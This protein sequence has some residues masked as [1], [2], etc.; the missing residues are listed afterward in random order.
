MMIPFSRNGSRHAFTLIELLVVITIIG[1][2]AGLAFP[3]VTGA[4]DAAKKAE[5]S[6]MINQLRVA[7]TSYNTEYGK[8]P[9]SVAGENDFN[10][11]E[12][13]QTLIGKD[14]PAENNPRQIAF[15][16]F[17]AKCLRLNATATTPPANP[18]TATLFVD[19]WNF[20]YNMIL[21]TNYDNEIALP[22][23]LT[24]NI[25][26][27]LAIWSTGKPKNGVR[28]VDPTKFVTS[29]K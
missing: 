24:G 23:P 8:W 14:D 26:S 19:P 6:S 20:S 11:D 25:N 2:L 16:E 13:Y 22:A 29:W 27:T 21:D 17:N 28:N 1:L 18:A 12:L 3:A 5:A 7:M 15:M 9:A 10:A 4:L